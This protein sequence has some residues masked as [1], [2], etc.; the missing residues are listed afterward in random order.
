MNLE[1]KD[2]GL[3]VEKVLNLRSLK[4]TLFLYEKALKQWSLRMWK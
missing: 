3:D 4:V 2:C 1:I